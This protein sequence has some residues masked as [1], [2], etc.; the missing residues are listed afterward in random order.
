VV[1]DEL[2]LGFT[3]EPPTGTEHFG[4]A[5]VE[6]AAAAVQK[7]FVGR[8]LKQRVCELQPPSCAF[9]RPQDVLRCKLRESTLQLLAG[10]A[11]RLE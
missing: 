11:Q 2:G 6:S 1:G 8:L 9:H 4:H 3:R 7:P 10:W 5:T